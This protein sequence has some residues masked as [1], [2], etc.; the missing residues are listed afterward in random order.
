V[1]GLYSGNLTADAYVHYDNAFG[2]VEYDYIDGYWAGYAVSTSGAT[3]TVTVMI[4]TTDV[5]GSALSGALLTVTLDGRNMRDTCN[6]N[7]I[8]FM[9]KRGIS[10]TGGI[11]SV[12]LIKNSCFGNPNKKYKAVL[13]WSSGKYE[14]SFTIDDTT[15]SIWYLGR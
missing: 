8:G 7:A 1:D 5:A 9:V 15:T 14:E 12:P 4:Q 6:N 11:A 2:D 13:A 10:G 3:D